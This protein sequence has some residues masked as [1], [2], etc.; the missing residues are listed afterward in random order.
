[1]KK[2]GILGLWHL[3]CVYSACLAEKGLDVTGYDADKA[4]VE[5]LQK[6]KSPIFEPGLEDLIKKNLG[7]MLGFTNN[8]KDAISGK[9]YIIIAIDTPVDNKDKVQMKSILDTFKL[10]KKFLSSKTTVVVSS[11]VPVG[12]CS[13]LQ[14][15]I[16]NLVL[17]LPENLRL[18]QAIEMFLNPDR[19]VLGGDKIARKKFLSDFSFFQSPVLEMSLESAEMSKHALN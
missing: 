8:R 3:G 7:K 5:S 6:G 10:L 1:M 9:D 4:V 16:K 18:G 2:I 13:T 12:T 11:Q 17:C 19:I 14:K 15:K